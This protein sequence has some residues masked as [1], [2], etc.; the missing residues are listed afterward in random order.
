MEK[1]AETKEAASADVNTNR[2]DRFMN[3]GIWRAFCT[4]FTPF[5]HGRTFNLYYSAAGFLMNIQQV[6]YHQQPLPVPSGTSAANQ[7]LPNSPATSSNRSGRP[8]SL[9][10]E[11]KESAVLG[12]VVQKK[13][14]DTWTK[15]DQKTLVNLWAERHK[16]LESKDARKVWEEIAQDINRKFSN[17]CQK[18]IKY[19][20]E[21]YKN[22]KDWKC[23]QTGGH[24]RYPDFYEE[25]DVVLGCR[26]VVTLRNVAEVGSSASISV[27][28]PT[29]AGE[30][31]SQE[32]SPKARTEQKRK[33]KRARTEEQDYEQRDL[34]KSS[35]TGL[36]TQRK[37][38]NAF[39]ESFI[40]V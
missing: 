13:Q 29:G 12:T 7:G 14:Y 24:S 9:E 28:T 30:K 32:S 8:N 36:E 40:K 26:N 31:E 1:F 18:K 35:L 5:H 33:R 11:D 27:A 3:S 2:F 34:L 15:E 20:I 25:I 10:V 21:K 23:K 38:M 37:D 4:L 16:R 19:Q 6:P 22:V 17:K 39:M